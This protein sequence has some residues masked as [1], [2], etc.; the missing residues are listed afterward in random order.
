MSHRIQRTIIHK[1]LKLVDSSNAN[2]LELKELL[3]DVKALYASGSLI[4]SDIYRNKLDYIQTKLDKDIEV[5]KRKRVNKSISIELSPDVK[6]TLESDVDQVEYGNTDLD[7]LSKFESSKPLEIS[8]ENVS[9]TLSNIL[10][11]RRK[12]SSESDLE[13][14]LL[15]QLALV[16]G[17]EKVSNQYSVG[18]FLALKT[19]LDVGNGLVGVELKIAENLTASEMQRLIGQVVYYKKRYY[20]NNL[21]VFIAGRSA[22]TS[23]LSELIEFLNELGAKVIYYHA[24]RD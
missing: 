18:G 16:F 5:L 19:D 1:Y 10:L 24:L 21:I 4:S 2:E 3:N 9:R 22:L 23:S 20:E 11:F 14:Y 17:K 13:K 8:L 15:A 7:E 12:L 6:A